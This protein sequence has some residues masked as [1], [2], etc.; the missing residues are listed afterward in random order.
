MEKEQ[1]SS[2]DAER[3]STLGEEVFTEDAII[4]SAS[5]KDLYTFWRDFT[6]FTLF[7][8]Q[9]ESVQVLSDT[10]SHWKWKVLKGKKVVEWDCEIVQDIPDSLIA[11]RTTQASMDL[12]HSG[13]VEFIQLPFNKGTE[14]HVQ[15]AY[16]LPGGRITEM[17]EK[18][19]GESPRRNLRMN[20]F[21]LRS[22]FEAKEIPTVEGQPAGHRREHETKTALH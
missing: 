1:I 19:I 14:V 16:D 18:V 4:I 11:W 21:K 6:H 3:L 17:V 20:L 7:T 13:R 10:L 2:K 8:D 15:L 5:T 22:Y 9:L 12:Q